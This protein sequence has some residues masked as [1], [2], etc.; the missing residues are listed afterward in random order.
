LKN[1]NVSLAQ[2]ILLLAL[3]YVVAIKEHIFVCVRM[4]TAADCNQLV[5]KSEQ[6]AM[7]A[8]AMKSA[9]ESKIHS[10]SHDVCRLINEKHFLIR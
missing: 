6:S 7:G 10:Q 9:P 2:I 4:H 5:G 1:A 8:A 3:V